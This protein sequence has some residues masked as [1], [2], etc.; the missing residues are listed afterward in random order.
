MPQSDRVAFQ[1]VQSVIGPF[2]FVGA[3]AGFW[4]DQQ[5]SDDGS[6]RSAEHAKTPGDLRC[7]VNRWSFRE[8]RKPFGAAKDRESWREKVLSR[9]DKNV[10][11][12]RACDFVVM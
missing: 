5:K 1:N 12:A 9:I 2:W 8:S 11:R 7:Y 4:T 3:V 10:Q 6:G